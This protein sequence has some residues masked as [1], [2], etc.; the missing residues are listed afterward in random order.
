MNLAEVI[1]SVTVRVLAVFTIKMDSRTASGE[2][3]D[4]GR[5]WIYNL[6]FI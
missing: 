4:G 1:S 3:A 2:L 5:I 6:Y